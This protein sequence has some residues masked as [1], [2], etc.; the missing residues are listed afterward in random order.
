MTRRVFKSYLLKVQVLQV[1]A[2]ERGLNFSIDTRKAGTQAFMCG[3]IYPEGTKFTAS[4]S[5]KD[6]YEY[7]FYSWQELQEYEEELV[8][9]EEW[10]LKHDIIKQ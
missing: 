6:F 7:F 5:G 4:E 2:Y 3:Y 10:I 9:M 8:R 1:R